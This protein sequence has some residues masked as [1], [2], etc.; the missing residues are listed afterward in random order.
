MLNCSSRSQKEKLLKYLKPYT[1]K[2]ICECA[3]NIINKNIKVSDQETR[4][5]NRN[6]DKVRELVNTRTLQKKRKKILVQEGDAFLAHFTSVRPWKF[7]GSPLEGD[8]RSK[9]TFYLKQHSNIILWNGQG[10][11]IYKDDVTEN[12]NVMDLLT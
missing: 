10:Q 2:A 11:M 9:T 8:H 5:I 12:S 1:I 7:G 3:I 6:R 4:K